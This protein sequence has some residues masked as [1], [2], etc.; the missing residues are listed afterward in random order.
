MHQSFHFL[1]MSLTLCPNTHM[2]KQQIR[3]Y[4]ACEQGILITAL[5]DE[6]S[7]DSKITKRNN[8]SPEAKHP[9]VTVPSI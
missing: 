2:L 4:V 3:L 8:K 6:L 5:A 1:S 9:K 7:I